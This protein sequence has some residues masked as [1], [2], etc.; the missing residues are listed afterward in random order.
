MCGKMV[1]EPLTPINYYGEKLFVCNQCLNE[2]KKSSLQKRH[3]EKPKALQVKNRPK[4]AEPEYDVVEEYSKIIREARG[5]INMTIP[6]LA[7]KIG[8]KESVLRRIEGGRL[9]PDIETAK[10]LER[11]L[12]VSLLARREEKELIKPSI[13]KQSELELRHVAK[14]KDND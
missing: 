6:E 1:N 9:E 10:K 7:L 12:H 14:L 2:S 11:Y 8:I 13:P 3:E 4:M 5:K